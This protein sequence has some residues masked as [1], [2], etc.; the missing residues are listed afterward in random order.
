[1]CVCVCVCGVCV[2]GVWYV[3]V[4]CGV[5]YVCVWCGVCVCVCVCVCACASAGEILLFKVVLGTQ[6]DLCQVLHPSE[7]PSLAFLD[8]ARPSYFIFSSAF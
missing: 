1:V 8:K 5:W 2:Y 6:P 4:W 7:L 3:C